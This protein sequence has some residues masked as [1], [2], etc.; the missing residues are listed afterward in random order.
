MLNVWIAVGGKYAISHADE[1]GMN[2]IPLV[3]LRF[4]R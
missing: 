2:D 3:R 4:V 1:F